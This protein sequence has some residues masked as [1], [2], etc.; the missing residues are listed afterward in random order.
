[1]MKALITKNE[2]RQFIFDAINEHGRNQVVNRAEI[3]NILN[4]SE[5]ELDQYLDKG[6]PWI[7]R[8]TRKKFNVNE[9]RKWL[10]ANTRKS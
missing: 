6:L 9:C 7:G 1:M 5:Y 10:D 8:P 2:I 3:R 4:I